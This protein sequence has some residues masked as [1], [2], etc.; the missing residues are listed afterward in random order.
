MRASIVFSVALLAG[1]VLAGTCA[2]GEDGLSVDQMELCA[3]VRDRAPVG[4]AESFPSDIARVYCF[5]R[6]VGAQDTVTV[7]HVWYF[8]DREMARIDLDV[9]SSS[10]RTWSSKKILPDYKGA[11]RVEVVESDTTI[12]ASKKFVLE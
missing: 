6:I 11:W 2:G 3:A 9:K 10:W 4:A 5:T 7:A 8:G 1:L 12:V